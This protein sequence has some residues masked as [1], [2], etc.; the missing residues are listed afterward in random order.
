MKIL[1]VLGSPRINGNSSTLAQ[2]FLD[3]AAH[4]GAT[5]QRCR[6]NDLDYR[7]CQACYACKTHLEH[8]AL[9]D[10]LSPVLT[11][12]GDCDLVL[13][14]TPVYYGDISAQTKAFIDRTFSFVNPNFHERDDPVRFAPGKKMV[15]IIT[16]ESPK[17][18]HEDIYQRY[19]NLFK[20]YAGF[21]THLI[22]ATEVE[23]PGEV[24][25]KP[26]VMDQAEL[27]ANRL[28]TDL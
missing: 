6:L 5:I 13:I 11:A 1:A 28:I 9:Q 12:L 25:G 26:K 4:R 20:D 15:W 27:L 19:G 24:S 21:D 2:R 8:C 18:H 10:G 17:G 16:Q 23:A 3:A 7:P 22:R 14:A